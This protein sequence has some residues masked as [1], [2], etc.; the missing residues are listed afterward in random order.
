MGAVV[1]KLDIFGTLLDTLAGAKLPG[2]KPEFSPS[3]G[4]GVAGE[5]SERKLAC[6]ASALSVEVLKGFGGSGGTLK[7]D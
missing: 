3:G 6:A 7:A 1:G 5:N 2:A 4:S